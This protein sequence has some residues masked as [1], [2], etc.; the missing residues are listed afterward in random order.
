[1]HCRVCSYHKKITKRCHKNLLQLLNLIVYSACWRHPFQ[2]IL[3][4]F[5]F[6]IKEVRQAF[7]GVRILGIGVLK[8]FDNSGLPNAVHSVTIIVTFAIHEYITQISIKEHIPVPS[9]L[10]RLLDPLME[11]TITLT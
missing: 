9:I 2:K 5:V 7:W 11:N 3:D 10:A 1:V 6:D 8:M 4:S